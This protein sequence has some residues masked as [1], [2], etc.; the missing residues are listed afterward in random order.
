MI[1]IYF[2]KRTKTLLFSDLSLEKIK[3]KY[4]YDFEIINSF[5]D[6]SNL[7][8]IKIKTLR[9]YPEH[10][11]VEAFKKIHGPKSEETRRK[12]SEAKKGKPRPTSS[13][14]KTS[15]KMKGKSNFQGKKHTEETKEV[16]S[17]IMEGNQKSKDLVWVHNPFNS[18]ETRVKDR[19]QVPDGYLLGR[20]YDSI[21]DI[22]YH[23]KT[24]IRRSS[25]R[26]PNRNQSKKGPGPY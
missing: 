22:I 15:L 23:A 11:I 5:A 4:G 10:K 25:T 18:R 21:E 14:L 2:F 6:K 7:D 8:I 26:S 3:K 19:S 1:H 17:E 9:F 13:N 24:R 16:L 20:D 12:M